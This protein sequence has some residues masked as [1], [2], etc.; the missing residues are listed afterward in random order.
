MAHLT[1]VV[2]EQSGPY[3]AVLQFP[4][5]FDAVVNQPVSPV[6]DQYGPLVQ[7]GYYGVFA[8]QVRTAHTI[9]QIAPGNI[10]VIAPYAVFGQVRLCPHN[11]FKGFHALVCEPAVQLV[12]S[13]GRRCAA[14]GYIYNSPCAVVLNGTQ[15]IDQTFYSFPVVAK[16]GVNAC[17][18]DAKPD[19][20][21]PLFILGRQPSK[22]KE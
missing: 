3:L 6:F 16:V 17:V 8:G 5:L 4:Q 11:L 15:E 2:F 18:V 13:L 9:P 7:D 21:L 14:K 1:E 20:I 12:A 10:A 19:S 22:M